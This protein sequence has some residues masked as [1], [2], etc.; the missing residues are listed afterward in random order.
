MMRKY[1]RP[2]RKLHALVVA[3]EAAAL[4]DPYPRLARYMESLAMRQAGL[5]AAGYGVIALPAPAHRTGIAA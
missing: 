1:E 5:R 3:I 2:S 4:H